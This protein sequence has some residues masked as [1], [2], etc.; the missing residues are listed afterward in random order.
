MPTGPRQHRT[1]L[2]LAVVMAGL[3]TMVASPAAA[4][5]PGPAVRHG[6]VARTPVRPASTP[7]LPAP[8]HPVFHGRD[9]LWIPDLGIDRKVSS[10]PCSRSAYPGDRVYRWGCAGSNNI[11]LFGHA[12]SVF[13][14]LHDAYVEGRLR[15]GMELVYADG[16]G[17]IST[18]AI[19]WWRVT[20]AD[21]GEFA[22]APQD[23]PSLTLQTC[24][25]RDSESRLIVRLVQTR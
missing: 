19:R 20:R 12:H 7:A 15:K 9:H 1:P 4:V 11:Y 2:A 18:Y 14:P 21:R 17:R 8:D 22:Y 3:L 16:D 5:G 13:E 23:R 10:F 6:S 25:G 24:V